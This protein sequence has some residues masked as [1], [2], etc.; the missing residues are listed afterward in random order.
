MPD[1]RSS[2]LH[3]G[4]RNAGRQTRGATCYSD[5]LLRQP[6]KSNHVEWG[7]LV[8]NQL[9]RA[10]IEAILPHRDPF[11]FVDTVVEIEP[12]ERIVGEFHV[13]DTVRFL[14]QGDDGVYLPSTVLTEAMAQVGAILVLHEQENRGRPIFFRSIEGAEFTGRVTVG[15]T[16]RILAEVRRMRSRVGTF[17]ITARVGNTVVAEGSMTFALG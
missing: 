12:K 5:A 15:Q 1:S 16:L 8:T 17:H 9:D 10:D 3:D 13:D 7:E 6:R 11:L 2:A 4:S 14:L